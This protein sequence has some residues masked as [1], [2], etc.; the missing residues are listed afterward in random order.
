[1]R[2]IAHKIEGPFVFAEDTALRGMITVRATVP[3]GIIVEVHGI[4]TGVLIVESGAKA[5]IHGMVNG[6][7][8][9]RGGSVIIFG[10]VDDVFDEDPGAQT[11]VMPNAV[12]KGNFNGVSTRAVRA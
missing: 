12:V 5:I 7:V 10:T 4:I 2:E 8:H 6:A 1:M 9:N 3:P 11:T